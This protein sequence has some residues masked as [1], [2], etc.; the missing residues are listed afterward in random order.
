MTIHLYDI[1]RTITNTVK[2]NA[3]FNQYV[4]DNLGSAMTYFSEAHILEDDEIPSFVT[5]S[6]ETISEENLTH[7]TVQ[8]VITAISNERAENVDGIYTYTV[9]KHLEYL[10]F[11][12]LKLVE[13]EIG[14]FGINGNTNISVAHKNL[15]FT[16]IGEADDVQ[17]IITIRL[18]E[19]LLL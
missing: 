12:S 6:L 9:K 10:A 15:M 19:Q 4:E 17:A 13:E 8:Y 11:E 16:E 5:Y 1:N 18:E 3:D 14:C 7:Y 2:S